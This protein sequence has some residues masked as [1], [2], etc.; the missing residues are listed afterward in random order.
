MASPASSSERNRKSRSQPACSRAVTAFVVAIVMLPGMC[1]DDAA[2]RYVVPVE[3]ALHAGSDPDVVVLALATTERSAAAADVQASSVD[4]HDAAA[5]TETS[6]VNDDDDD[7][8]GVQPGGTDTCPVENTAALSL[9]ELRLASSDL[10]PF[11]ITP[12]TAHRMLEMTPGALAG[13][14]TGDVDLVS[15]TRGKIA[16]QFAAMYRAVAKRV[17]VLGLPRI[18]NESAITRATIVGT[19]STYNPYRDG[20]E[21]GGPQTASGEPY[22]P[23]AWTAAIKT[24]LRNQFGGVRYGR[25]YQ[26]AFALVESGI[27]KI[28]VKI[29]DVGPLKTGRV[30]DLNERSMRHFDPFLTRG[31]IENAKVTLLPGEDWTPGPIGKV[32]AVD[33]GAPERRAEPSRFGT[34]DSPSWQIDSDSARLRA[35]RAPVSYPPGTENLRAEIRPSEGG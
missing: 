24:S 31:L 5:D 30:L 16:P 11:A 15:Y 22:D 34:I 12:R 8:I 9:A 1:W 35:P 27:K 29:N 20:A 14:R 3:A 25:L 18:Q 33:L 28:I 23:A 10:M 13:M 26:P 7:D 32:Y 6:S 19:V 4:D 17:A 21:E 2:D